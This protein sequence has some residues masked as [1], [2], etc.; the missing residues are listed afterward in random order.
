MELKSI[1]EYP[2]ATKVEIPLTE[3][4]AKMLFYN[5]PDTYFGSTTWMNYWTYDINS[6]T[7][8]LKSWT[9]IHLTTREEFIPP[10]LGT[11]SVELL[12]SEETWSGVQRLVARIH[13]EING[14]DRRIIIELLVPVPSL[15]ERSI[16]FLDRFRS[17]A[18]RH[19]GTQSDTVDENIRKLMKSLDEIAQMEKVLVSKGLAPDAAH[20]QAVKALMPA[21]VQKLLR[22]D[23][24]G[25]N[26]ED[27]AKAAQMMAEVRRAKMK[28]G[29]RRRTR[30]KA[31][32]V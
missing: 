2:K 24:L 8:P 10:F 31:K 16:R 13:G 18:N 4:V 19:Y 27:R 32:K 26:A 14:S 23:S 20:D 28:F 9:Q 3:R 17:F 21:D 29:G 5:L 15:H 12:L 25:G 7:L 6:E 11:Q 1:K 22:P 30:R